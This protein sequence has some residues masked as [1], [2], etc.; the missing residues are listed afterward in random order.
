MTRSRSRACVG[1]IAYQ[2][3]PAWRARR[4]SPRLWRDAMYTMRVA[5]W[6]GGAGD[7]Y[8]RFYWTNA[9]LLL[10]CALITTAF[11]VRLLEADAPTLRL[12]AHDP[13]AGERP[14]WVRAVSYR[15]RF[16]TRAQFRETHA[17][18]V[19]DRRRPVMGPV[20][21]RR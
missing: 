5:A 7:P 4:S 19:R 2:V 6:V 18:W 12:L 14:R 16:S 8:Q 21:L 11:L 20:T 15:Y 1:L 13:F 3:A 10:I 17:R 9:A